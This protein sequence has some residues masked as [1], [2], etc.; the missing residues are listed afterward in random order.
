MSEQGQLSDLEVIILFIL[1]GE[2]SQIARPQLEDRMLGIHTDDLRGLL[3]DDLDESSIG[4]LLRPATWEFDEAVESLQGKQLV[5][6]TIVPV[7]QR[8]MFMD[9]TITPA[10]QRALLTFREQ[11]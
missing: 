1:E 3:G 11:D 9:M 6:V 8:R 5:D 4:S 10:G 7:Q 2:R